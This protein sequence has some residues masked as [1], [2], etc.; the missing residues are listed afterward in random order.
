MINQN[1]T[2][3]FDAVGKDI[4]DTGEEVKSGRNQGGYGTY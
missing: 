2:D 3:K 4:T 1:A